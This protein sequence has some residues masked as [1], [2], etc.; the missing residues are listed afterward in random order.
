M[1][2]QHD[3]RGAAEYLG[4]SP[5]TLEKWRVFGE[6]PSFYKVGAAV[7]YAEQDLDQWLQ[8]RRRRSTSDPGSELC[9]CA[10]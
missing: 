10:K 5:K 3:T 9:G 4:M 6:G 8:G 2:I 7:R 1:K